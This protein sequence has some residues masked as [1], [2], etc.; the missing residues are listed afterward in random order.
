MVYAKNLFLQQLIFFP[1][2][3]QH[4]QVKLHLVKRFSL[5][6]FVGIMKYIPSLTDKQ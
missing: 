4:C 5:K 3:I 1:I 6:K 2:Q